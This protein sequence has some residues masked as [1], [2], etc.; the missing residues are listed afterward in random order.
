[1]ESV[2]KVLVY[3]KSVRGMEQL[4]KRAWAEYYGTKRKLVY[5]RVFIQ[6]GY[7]LLLGLLTGLL[8][9]RMG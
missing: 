3:M 8:L 7:M 4:T 1:M 2:K 9:D 6:I 5:Q